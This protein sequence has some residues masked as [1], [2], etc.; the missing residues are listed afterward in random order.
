MKQSL[1]FPAALLLVAT[2]SAASPALSMGP[3]DVPA[4]VDTI[5]MA[6]PG[7]SHTNDSGISGFDGNQGNDLLVG[8]AG[9]VPVSE[10]IEEPVDDYNGGIW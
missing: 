6:G 10:P 8:N 2:L 1:S 9:G 4:P 7:Q 5:D 3:G